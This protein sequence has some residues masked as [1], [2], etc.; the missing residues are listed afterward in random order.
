MGRPFSDELSRLEET[1]AWALEQDVSAIAEFFKSA[2]DRPLLAVG[3]GGSLSAASYAA[4]LHEQATGQPA[5][6]LTPMRL[7]G[8]RALRETAVLFLSA[9]GKNHDILAAMRAALLRDLHQL[10][11]ISLR[12]KNPLS[13]LAGKMFA[14]LFSAA[15]PTGSD[16]FLATNGLVAFF[17]ILFRAHAARDS[18][19][20]S[21]PRTYAAL[22]TRA[23]FS[24][25]DLEEVSGRQHVVVLYSP[26][27]FS[28]ALDIESKFFE[29]GLAAVQLT[30]FRN[31]AHGRHNWIAKHQASTSVLALYGR[32]TSAVAEKT[33]DLLGDR[34]PT[35]TVACDGPEALHSFAALRAIFDATMLAGQA[36]GVDPGRPG[37]PAFGRRI[38]HL[39]GFDAVPRLKGKTNLTLA[40]Q[41]KAGS[42]WEGLHVSSQ[43]RWISA[44]RTYLRSL[45]RAT[46]ASILFDF[47]E[48][49]CSRGQRFEPLSTQVTAE[50]E[51]LIQAGLTIGI[52]TG[53]GK[54]VRTQV[55]QSLARKYWD[56]V[57][58]GYYNGADIS[59]LSDHRHPIVR[60][61]LDPA[62]QDVRTRLQQD[63]GVNTLGRIEYRPMQ[64]TVEPT[65]HIGLYELYRH[66][67]GLSSKCP[68]PVKVLMSSHSI[69]IVPVDVSKTAVAHQLSIASAASPTLCI[70]DSG[71]YPGN[72]FELLGEPFSL[73]CDEV[74]TDLSSC[75]NFA[76]A[77]HRGVKAALFYLHHLVLRQGVAVLRLP[78][79]HQTE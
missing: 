9:S 67:Q 51:R 53:R 40:A 42:A 44:A 28:A 50:L 37:V 19:V 34:V 13:E 59:R 16:G 48:T 45:Q 69:D 24:L 65:V 32:D 68:R 20:G 17:A 8:Q 30:D 6:A 35:A 23:R 72:D 25:P 18:E 36:R 77:S 4:Y 12:S 33:L 26:S 73:S 74:S 47:D 66:L 5:Q 22:T 55:Q 43:A 41:R 10:G 57:W 31:F 46:F 78:I 62:L 52:A 39:R 56:R 38:Y 21:L 27:T 76:P 11:S 3:S 14:D 15:P 54:S 60:R 7:V 29:A 71:R 49:L 75:W 61:K 79:D 58:I 63:D 64:I 70:G 1:Y 2:A